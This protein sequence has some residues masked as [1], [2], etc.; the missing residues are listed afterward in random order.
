MNLLTREQIVAVDDAQYDVIEVPEWGG[1]VRVRGMSGTQRD[2]YESLL[3]E[4]RGDSRKINLANARSKLVVRCIVDE[5]GHLLFTDDDV[6]VL[7]KKSAKALERV[8]DKAR[9][10]SG[11][12]KEDIEKL[13][14]NFD[15]DPSESGTSD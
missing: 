2:A 11:M 3:L 8:F 7:G 14:E 9:E 6:R 13:T 10:L 1:S 15:D 5:G 4:Q 12:S